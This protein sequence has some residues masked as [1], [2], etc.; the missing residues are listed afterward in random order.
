MP[1]HQLNKKRPQVTSSPSRSTI[2]SLLYA[3]KSSTPVDKIDRESERIYAQQ[4]LESHPES[5][6]TQSSV[7][8]VLEGSKEHKD[9]EMMASL[10]DDIKTMKDTFGLKDVPRE[11]LLLGIAGVLPYA[12]TSLG[13]VFLA[14]DLNH[15]NS[16]G[17]E[18]FFTRETAQYLL[19]MM[20]PIQIGYGAVIISF[21]GAIH[22]GLEYA[23]YGGHS[24]RRFAYGVIAPAVAWP[25]L[26]MSHEYALI[27]QFLAFIFQYF[28]DVQATVRGWCP[29]WYSTYRFVL[30]FFVGASLVLS[31]V[32]RGQLE[33]STLRVKHGSD[34]ADHDHDAKWQALERE[35][36]ERRAAAETAAEEDGADDEVEESE[37]GKKGADKSDE[38]K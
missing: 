32:G 36:I 29:P 16:T 10:K 19:D 2:S 9:D 15:T 34:A 5:V 1:L 23:G 24:H 31:L 27:T 3:T 14:Y 35:E 18:L 20:L 7:R 26:L 25:T 4:K 37:D 22:W 12:V 30:T 6:S 8:H 21:L 33:Q 28:T 17:I 11:P 13:T 38:K